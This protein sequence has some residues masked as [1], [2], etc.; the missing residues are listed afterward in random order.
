MVSE[1]SRTRKAAVLVCCVILHLLS[2]GTGYA[3]GVIYVELIR[4]FNSPRTDAALV[5]SIYMGIMTAGGNNKR[6]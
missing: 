6:T 4:V 5:Q 2:G 1:T 3:L